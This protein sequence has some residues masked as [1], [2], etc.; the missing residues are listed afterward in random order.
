[1]FETT[2]PEDY[3][4]RLAASDLGRGY[5]ALALAE[6]EIR[7]GQV[8]LDLGCGPGADLP[9]FAD[10]TGDRGTV[11]G[12][13]HDPQAVEQARERTGAL[14]QVQVRRGDIHHL[15]LA[16]RSVD[17]AHTDRVLQHVA[18]PSA[19]LAE[20]RR[21]LCPGSRAVF[22]EP[23]WDT[24][25]IDYP[26][27]G[28]ARAYTRFVTEQAV[29]NAG[30]G[31][32]LARL[33]TRA[34]FTV[35]KVIPITATFHDR[36]A[37]DKVLGLQRVTARAVAAHYLT[38]HD[39]EQWLHHLAAEPFFASATLFIVAVSVYEPAGTHTTHRWRGAG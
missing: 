15:D 33:A 9:A 22:A 29:R 39:A 14:A 5:K 37:A 6:L 24:L 19:V 12:V 21:V 18:D 23:D 36:E 4:L 1:M 38:E 7:P 32:Q 31:R 20:T 11:L 3:L 10:A 25:I 16:D 35:D 26:D 30:I 17:R 27:L 28:V 2:K 8:V 13:D 34:G